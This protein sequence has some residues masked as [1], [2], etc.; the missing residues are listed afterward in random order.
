MSFDHPN[1]KLPWAAGNSPTKDV[2]DLRKRMCFC[3][4]N[5]GPPPH[6]VNSSPQLLKLSLLAINSSG[7][8]RDE[9]VTPGL[10]A[11]TAWNKAL[12]HRENNA[13]GVAIAHFGQGALAQHPKY[14]GV[15]EVV[16]KAHASSFFLFY[17]LFFC[18]DYNI[19]KLFSPSLFLLPNHP[20]HSSLLSLKFMDSFPINCCYMHICTWIYS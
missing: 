13:K 18:C 5:W 6:L 1:L 17:Y 8:K 14:T 20:T 9:L 12:F 16:R 10:P 19:I 4:L 11:G 7:K 15:G 2:C 3:T